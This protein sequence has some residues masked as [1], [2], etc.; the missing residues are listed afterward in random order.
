[1]PFPL[2]SSSSLSLS[3]TMWLLNSKTAVLHQFNAPED[4]PGGYAILSHVWGKPEEEDTFQ[5][6]K[7]VAKTCEE[8]AARARTKSASVASPGPLTASNLLDVVAELQETIQQ[9]AQILSTLSARMEQLE[10]GSQP[11]VPASETQDASEAAPPVSRSSMSK[12]VVPTSTSL[13]SAAPRDSKLIPP[14]IRE[15]LIKAEQDGYEWAWADTC[16]IDKTSSTALTEAI[17]SMFKYYS[18]S[19]ICYVYLADV[20]AD[21]LEDP[22]KF[23]EGRWQRR[24]WTLQELLAPHNVVFMSRDWT[25]LGNKYTLATALEEATGIPASVLRLEQDFA[26]MSVAVRMSWAATRETTRVEDEAYCLLGIFGVNMPTIYGEG[27]NAFYRLQEEIVRYSTDNTFLVW[28][29]RPTSWLG[30]FDHINVLKWWATRHGCTGPPGHALADSPREF[31]SSAGVKAGCVTT[32]EQVSPLYQTEPPLVNYIWLHPE[33]TIATH[34]DG[35]IH[36][37]P[38]RPPRHASNV[39]SSGRALHCA[40]RLLSSTHRRHPDR[41]TTE[42]RS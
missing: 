21:T 39:R 23:P 32:D 10:S 30:V 7:A 31:S 15:F 8:N 26:T 6:V 18:F 40:P 25:L 38:V 4:V 5:S 33:E 1:M 17:N 16:C 14:K 13:S 28:G 2:S 24:G 12:P 35:S 20:A 3:R 34:R 29:S 9:Q 22:H 37:H 19:D 11:Y 36:N 41:C 42:S 27:K